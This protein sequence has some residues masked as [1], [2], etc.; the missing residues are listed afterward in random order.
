MRRMLR[1]SRHFARER[2]PFAGKARAFC[3][4]I[5]TQTAGKR[6]AEASFSFHEMS[7]FKALER[8]LLPTPRRG[9]G[10]ERNRKDSP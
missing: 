6:A 3:A 8:I 1:A 2:A 9:A 5:C 4:E 7:D 10:W